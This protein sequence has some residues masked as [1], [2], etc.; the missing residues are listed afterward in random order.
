MANE[1]T[2]DLEPYVAALRRGQAARLA[3]VVASVAYPDIPV[4]P[5]PAHGTALCGRCGR[6]VP[7]MDGTTQRTGEWVCW[8]CL[9]CCEPG[10]A[11][12]CRDNHNDLD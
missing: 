1:I 4:A 10:C 8:E 9:H 7:T 6:E 3:E 12:H 11:C 5:G 2:H